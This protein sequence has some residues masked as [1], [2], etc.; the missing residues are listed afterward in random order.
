MSQA[1]EV[2]HNIGWAMEQLQTGRT[3]RRLL[4][5]LQTNYAAGGRA[6][7]HLNVPMFIEDAA[8][9]GLYRKFMQVAR[10]EKIK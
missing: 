5:H 9:E 6:N 8:P 10:G 2:P 7:N 4:L 3:V 1:A